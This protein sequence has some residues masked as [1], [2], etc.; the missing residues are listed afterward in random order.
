[1]AIICAVGEDIHDDPTAFGRAISALGSIPLRMVVAGRIAPE[2]HL[3]LERCRRSAGYDAAARGVLRAGKELE[4]SEK[5]EDDV[6][7]TESRSQ[8]RRSTRSACFGRPR[9]RR[10]LSDR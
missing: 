5:D 3:C 7:A 4:K 9:V 1:M 6:L 8:Q 10:T 2:Y